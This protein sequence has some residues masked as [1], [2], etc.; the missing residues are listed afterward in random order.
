MDVILP[1]SLHIEVV[2]LD[3]P[4]YELYLSE[5]EDFIIFKPVIKYQDN[6]GLI[7]PLTTYSI[8]QSEDTSFKRYDILQ[9]DA[10]SFTDF[11]EVAHDDFRTANRQYGQYFLHINTLMDNMWFFEFFDQCRQRNIT[12]FG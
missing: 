5:S 4:K 6:I 11:L 7:L 12:I 1:D 8:Y 10:E 9:G 3:M 2:Q